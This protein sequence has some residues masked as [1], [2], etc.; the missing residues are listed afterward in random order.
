MNKILMSFK[1]DTKIKRKIESIAKKHGISTSS[2]INV[3]LADYI[4][5]ERFKAIDR[6]SAKQHVADLWNKVQRAHSLEEVDKIF[7]EASE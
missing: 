4:K 7:K 3:V 5:E 1:I 2:L 6:K